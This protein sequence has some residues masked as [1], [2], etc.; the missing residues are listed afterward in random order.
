M[1]RSVDARL[2]HVAKLQMDEMFGD[3]VVDKRFFLDAENA[4]DEPPGSVNEIM[5]DVDAH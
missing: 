1:N 3:R 2:K 4:A 5:N